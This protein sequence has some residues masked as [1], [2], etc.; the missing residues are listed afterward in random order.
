M[1]GKREENEACISLL[2]ILPTFFHL[3]FV[4]VH[5]AGGDIASLQMKKSLMI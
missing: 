5:V 4:V 1:W 3:L 2:D